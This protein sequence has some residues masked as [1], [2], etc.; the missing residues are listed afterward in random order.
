MAASSNATRDRGCTVF[1]ALM[2]M[3]ESEAPQ[4]G[5]GISTHGQGQYPHRRRRRCDPHRPEPGARPRR[6]RTARHRQRGDAV[7]LD[8]PGRRRPRH[9]R[10]ADAR[11]ERLRSHSA[12]EEA[13]ARPADHRDERAEHLHDRD[14]RGGAGGLRISAQALRSE[15]ARRRRGPRA[16]RAATQSPAALRRDQ[17]RPAADRPLPGHAGHL[18]R[19]CPP[20]PDRPHGDDHRRVGHRQ[21][22]GRARAA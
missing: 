21:G 20:H 3:A 11:R 13:P 1:R 15:R 2:P 19:A 6:L 5:H 4:G 9:H 16:R 18:S 8:Q 14:H 12:G 7:A 10:R 17:R 22:A